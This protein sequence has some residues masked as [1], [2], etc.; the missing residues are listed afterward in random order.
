MIPHGS[1]IDLILIFKFF[2]DSSAGKICDFI[3]QWI[4]D[5]RACEMRVDVGKL[6]LIF[7]FPC[8]EPFGPP[9]FIDPK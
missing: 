4:M 7:F 8:M 9:T 5:F 6:A 1:L 3:S 2:W